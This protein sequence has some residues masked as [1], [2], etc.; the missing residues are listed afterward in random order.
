MLEILINP[1]HLPLTPEEL[2]NEILEN[3]KELQKQYYNLNNC[4]LVILKKDYDKLKN[5]WSI[6]NKDLITREVKEWETI[7]GLKFEII[8]GF[9]ENE[10]IKY[11]INE[12]QKAIW[13]E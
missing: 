11:C 1:L 4:M 9:E 10:D 12:L 13:E 3:R 2:I 5:Y 6:L 7:Y 8:N